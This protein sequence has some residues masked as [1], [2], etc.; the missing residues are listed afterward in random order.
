MPTENEL[1]WVLR[2]DCEPEVKKAANNSY[3]LQQAYLEHAHVRVRKIEYDKKKPVFQL[4]YKHHTPTRLIEIET[5]IEERDFSNLWNAAH[6]RLVKKR[7]ELVVDDKVWVVDFFKSKNKTYFVQA[8][9][10]MPEMQLKPDFIPDIIS[11][12]VIYAVAHADG[13]FTIGKLWNVEY[14][15]KLYGIVK[16]RTH[17]K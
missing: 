6:E 12:N 8:E 2:L 13:R 11:K 16:G 10:E 7:Y 4:C 3:W 1:K 15:K 5:N 9:H 17:E 14:A